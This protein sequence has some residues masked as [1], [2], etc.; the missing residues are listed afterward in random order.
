MPNS[1]ISSTEVGQPIGDVDLTD[2]VQGRRG[3]MTEMPKCVPESPNVDHHHHT[4]QKKSDTDT[5]VI[6]RRQTNVRAIIV[7]SGFSQA[8]DFLT[9]AHRPTG[10]ML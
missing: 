8:L 7:V 10:K 3:R 2:G 4:W 9:S 6:N 5:F 1:R